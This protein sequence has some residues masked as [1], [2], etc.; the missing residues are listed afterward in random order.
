MNNEDNIIT[1]LHRFYAN[2]DPMVIK[3][4][5]ADFELPINDYIGR[6]VVKESGK[7]FKSRK[8]I[9]TVAGMTLHPKLNS[10]CWTF[11]EDDSYVECRRCQFLE[12]IPA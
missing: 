8:K 3:A 10:P 5:E 9:N 1:N 4:F 12:E 6:K 11:M 7:P 2:I